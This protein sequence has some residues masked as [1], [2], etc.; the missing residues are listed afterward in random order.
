MWNGIRALILGYEDA[1]IVSFPFRTYVKTQPAL[2]EARWT[3]IRKTKAAPPVD[4]DIPPETVPDS[5]AEAVGSANAGDAFM[6]G[7]FGEAVVGEGL[8]T[9]E[10]VEFEA[11]VAKENGDD[12]HRAAG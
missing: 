4:K 7:I 9:P 8:G 11:P 5:A 1:Y 10:F 12:D 6:A 3:R 2:I